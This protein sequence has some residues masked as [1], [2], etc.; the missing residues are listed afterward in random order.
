M[1]KKQGYIGWRDNQIVVEEFSDEVLKNA[2]N[3]RAKELSW[4][5]AT[6]AVA[7]AM[8]KTDFSET[9]GHSLA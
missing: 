7:P 3:E 4:A 2:A 8:P 1:G 5:R 6:V 9:P